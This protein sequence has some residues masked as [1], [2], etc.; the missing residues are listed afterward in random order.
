MYRKHVASWK[1]QLVLL[2]LFLILGFSLFNMQVINGERYL[3]IS[4]NNYVRI[5]KI[6]P[7]RG[8]IF[9]RKYRE[10]ASNTSSDNLHFTLS[11]LR[12]SHRLAQFISANFDI[13]SL[14]VLKIIHDNRFRKYHDISLVKGLTYEKLVEIAERM[15]EFPS[16]KFKSEYVRQYSYPNHFTGHTGPVSESEYE[17]YK[18][19]GY[20]LNSEIGKNGLEKQYEELLHGTAGFQLIQVDATGKS[21]EFLKHNLYKPALN[22]KDLILSVDNDLQNY[23]R[24]IFPAKEKGAVVVMDVRTGGILAYVSMPEFDPNVYSSA[25]SKPVWESMINNPDK[26]MLDRIS[27]GTYPPG[28]IFKMITASLALEAGLI[29]PETKMTECTGGLQVGDR[30]F[31]CWYAAGHGRLSVSD[32][33]KY[34]CDV[35]FY[36]VSLLIELDDM[37]RFTEQNFLTMKTGVD[38]PTERRGF[39]PDERWYIENYGRYTGIIGPKVNLSIG[40]G[41]LLITPLE[42]CA[43][44]SA[45]A[46]DG[47]WQQPHFLEEIIDQERVPVRDYENRRLPLSEETVKL[48]QHALD[49][50]VN[51][52][53]GTGAGAK[54]AG[55][56]VCGKTGSAENHMGDET[57][58]WFAGY[59]EWEEPEIAF[60]VFV[61]NG[62]H[63][64]AKAAPLASELVTFYDLLR[65]NDPQNYHHLLK[66]NSED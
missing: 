55:V 11:R 13:D 24:K 6:N 38:L 63:G 45:L 33:I 18:D 60:V 43:Y 16:L 58:A 12:D 19:K 2:G 20:S 34:S 54:V 62:G 42:F 9:D 7:L 65:T 48:L 25:I 59:A 26:P 41:E 22:G 1:S 64:G 52:R 27:N 23:I 10:I 35:F 66:G 56:K 40:Q 57:H 8:N 46:N 30:F 32:A 14:S 47:I 51:E 4:E 3:A 5:V 49:R 44:Y 21:L 36:D 61:E 29:T 37:K 17:I 28:S 53:W 15:N 31:G 39:F 50:T